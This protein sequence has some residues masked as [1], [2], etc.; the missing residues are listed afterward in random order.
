MSGLLTTLTQ[1]FRSSG[2]QMLSTMLGYGLAF[3]LVLISIGAMLYAMATA[4][5]AVYGPVWAA[6]SIAAVCLLVAGLVIGWLRLRA[7]RLHRRLRMR[8]PVQPG[9][10]G[11]ATTLLPTMVRASPIGTLAA[12]AA[13]AYVLQRAS[14]VDRAQR[15]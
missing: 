8:A 15:K 6:L 13:A 14:E 5:S 3:L 10:A 11:L 2:E 7:R 9:M 4:V 12:I 1:R